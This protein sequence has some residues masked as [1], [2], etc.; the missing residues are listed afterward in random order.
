MSTEKENIQS[1]EIEYR[2][3][4]FTCR[5][6]PHCFNRIKSKCIILF[7]EE[8]DSYQVSDYQANPV[9]FPT[10]NNSGNK[11]DNCIYTGL[12]INCAHKEVCKLQKP[13]GGIW[14]CEEYE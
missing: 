9:S 1:T 7:C 10:K 11:Q 8:F 6:A 2:G 14:H 4:C 13:E 3:L 12:C 5:H